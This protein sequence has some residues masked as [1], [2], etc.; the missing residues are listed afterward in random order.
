MP[1]N[2]SS[3]AMNVAS[4]IAARKGSAI[5]STPRMTNSTPQ[6]MPHLEPCF[7]KASVLG[8][9]VAIECPFDS[10]RLYGQAGKQCVRRI[11][12]DEGPKCK[13]GDAIRSR[14]RSLAVRGRERAT[15]IDRR[16][17]EADPPQALS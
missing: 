11:L 1:T 6:M 15:G 17:S 12:A 13:H 2:T 10:S 4:A 16:Q 7:T 3:Q 8:S 14:R 9:V 5:A